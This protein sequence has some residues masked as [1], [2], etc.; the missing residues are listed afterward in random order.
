MRNRALLLLA[1]CSPFFSGC[2]T[3]ADAMA[4]PIDGHLYYRGV[5]M[6]IAG[7]RSGLPIMVLDLPFSAC[8]DTLMVPSIAFHQMTHPGA[9]H[10]SALHVVGEELGKSITND[11]IVPMTA[12]MMNADAELRKQQSTSPAT[13]VAFPK[14]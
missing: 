13:P 9:E 10:K 8:T 5:R 14:D 11:V 12:E 4:G 1:I 3:M 7:I 2:G 6:D